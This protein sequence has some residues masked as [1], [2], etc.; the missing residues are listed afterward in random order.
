MQR[1]TFETALACLSE[2]EEV[3]RYEAYE[4]AALAMHHQSR[5]AIK[6]TGGENVEI[7]EDGAW[8]AIRVWVPRSAIAAE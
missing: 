7:L 8:V 2:A 5:D 1:S 3:S 4:Q 6:V